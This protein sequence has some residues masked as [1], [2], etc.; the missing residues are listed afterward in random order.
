MSAES[1]I[2]QRNKVIVSQMRVIVCMHLL[3]LESGTYLSYLY[4][5]ADC[6]SAE[7]LET[8]NLCWSTCKQEAA[9]TSNA[10]Y[11]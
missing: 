3:R 1:I 9:L 11:Q 8:Y 2:V 5:F 7:Q 4:S 10:L 6:L